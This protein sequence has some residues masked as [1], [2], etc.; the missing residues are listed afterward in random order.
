MSGPKLDKTMINS[1]I[2]CGRWIRIQ[3]RS[4]GLSSLPPFQQ[5]REAEKRDPGNKVDPDIVKSDDVTESCFVSY[6]TINRYGGTTSRSSFSRPGTI[7]CVWTRRF[8][9]NAL[10]VDGEILESG[11]KCYGL[12]NRSGYLWTGPKNAVVRDSTWLF[13]N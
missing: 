12:K 4:Q 2:T 6:R 1:P 9:L 7:G 5:P 10:R 13:E 11:K 8:D 3:P